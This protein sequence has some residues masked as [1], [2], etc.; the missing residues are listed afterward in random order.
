MVVTRALSLSASAVSAKLYLFRSRR[1]G[2]RQA[3]APPPNAAGPSGG[4]SFREAR[5]R[6]EFRSRGEKLAIWRVQEGVYAAVPSTLPDSSQLYTC[7]NLLT[8]HSVIPSHLFRSQPS[9]LKKIIY[10]LSLLAHLVHSTLQL[11]LP[12][13]MSRCPKCP[14]CQTDWRYFRT[15]L[16]Q[17]LVI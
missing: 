6:P 15:H 10:T 13:K 11:P 2:A 8:S 4:C 12:L 17:A 7:S 5:L 16:T 14:C 3:S 1:W 9:F